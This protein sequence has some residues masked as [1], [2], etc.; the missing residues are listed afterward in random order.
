MAN[1]LASTPHLIRDAATAVVVLHPDA[2]ADA[3][4]LWAEARAFTTA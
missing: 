4:L 2:D 1:P 3:V